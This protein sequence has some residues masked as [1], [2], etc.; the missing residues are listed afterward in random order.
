MGGDREENEDL[1]VI[2]KYNINYLFI[3]VLLKNESDID[4][5]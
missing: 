4:N 3:K 5:V 1:I 2:R